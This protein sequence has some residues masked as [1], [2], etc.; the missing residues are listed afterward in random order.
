MAP[1]GRA[2]HAPP[3]SLEFEL[4]RMIEF[5]AAA[6]AVYRAGPFWDVLGDTHTR[7]LATAGFENFKRTVNLRYFN[8]RPLG[9][10]R[11]QFGAI[12]LEW[13]KHPSLETVR[14]CR[15]ASAPFN[16]VAA[17]MYR[18]Y[19]AMYC[20]VLRR[21][22]TFGLLDHLEEPTLGNPIVVTCRGRRMSQDL[23]NSV[24]EFYSIHGVAPDSRPVDICELGAGYGRLAHLTLEALPAA[25]YCI[26][27]IPPALYLSQRYLSELFPHERI[28]H[29]RPFARFDDV[30][31][32]F[33]SS[34]IRFLAAPQVELL[35]PKTF[36]YFINISSLHEMTGEQVGNYFGH[37]DRVCR[38]RVYNKQFRSHRAK[39]G[40]SILREEA[41]FRE[42]EY[43]VPTAWRVVYH[44]RHPV[45]RLFFEALYEVGS[46]SPGPA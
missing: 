5:M 42:S 37:M 27:D 20:D 11:H 24:H 25:T 10:L 40:D 34:R 29:F 1:P 19:V 8:W 21:S 6:P 23:C 45:Q 43:P 16:A 4:A 13:L 15:L 30:R 7:L 44:R 9:I 33:E 46:G 14:E 32:E 12:A 41:A 38:G 26:I 22:D 35:P 2:E 31:Q 28:F 18:L 39:A 3:E 36:D 17:M